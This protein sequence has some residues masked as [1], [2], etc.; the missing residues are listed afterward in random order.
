MAIKDAQIASTLKLELIAAFDEVLGLNL[1]E[2]KQPQLPADV[3]AVIKE[4]ERVRAAGEWAQADQLRASL[5]DRGIMLKD[6]KTGT[7]WYLA[8]TD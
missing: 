4:R 1:A 8:I 6:T 5:A 7:E 3:V 2:A